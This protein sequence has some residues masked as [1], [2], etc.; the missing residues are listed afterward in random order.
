MADIWDNPKYY[1]IS[2]LAAIF[3]LQRRILKNNCK[4][5]SD[6]YNELSIIYYKFSNHKT[7]QLTNFSH[8]IG[9][10]NP[11]IKFGRCNIS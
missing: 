1:R 11:F 4:I 5:L 7:I 10:Y 9:W 6:Y 8:H 3:F 2:G